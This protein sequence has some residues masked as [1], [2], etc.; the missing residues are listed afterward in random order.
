MPSGDVLEMNSYRVNSVLSAN[1]LEHLYML[2]RQLDASERR[3]ASMLG[4]LVRRLDHLE[5]RVSSIEE[6]SEIANRKLELDIAVLHD[7][8]ASLERTLAA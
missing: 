7:R 4:D 8:L 3:T 6:N 5:M 2:E 1:P